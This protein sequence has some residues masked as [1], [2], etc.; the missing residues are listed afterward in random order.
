[1]RRCRELI[2][3]RSAVLT[4]RPIRSAVVRLITAQ[5]FL[6][7]SELGRNR[8]FAIGYPPI[9]I[10]RTASS[11]SGGLT[12]AMSVASKRASGMPRTTIEMTRPFGFSSRKIAVNS[13][14]DK[15]DS[16]LQ[17]IIRS[18]CSL[19]NIAKACCLLRL[20]ATIQPSPSMTALRDS[21]RTMSAEIIKIRSAPR[22]WSAHMF[23]SGCLPRQGTL[24]HTLEP[25]YFEAIRNC[26]L[27][28]RGAVKHCC[29]DKPY[30]SLT[31]G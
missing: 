22:T 7:G 26:Y 23:S 4:Y 1:M 11:N 21:A 16:E 25:N 27:V 31:C 12:G 15:D 28:L 5:T 6:A 3:H 20:N 14:C 24:M 17:R 10:F 13:S 30:F 19:Y 18:N 8:C 2:S 29:A 9:S